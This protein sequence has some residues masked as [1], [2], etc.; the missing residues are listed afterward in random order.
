MR[1]EVFNIILGTVNTMRGT[2]VLHNTTM[3]SAPMVNQNFFEDMLAEEAN[4]HWATH[5][6]MLL[7]WTPWGGVASSTPHRYQEEVVL[8]SRP[9]ESNHPEEVGFHVA[10]CEFRKMWEPKISK[11]KGHYSSSAG[12]I[13]QS[14]LKDIC[15]HVE[16]RKLTQREAIQLVK[17]FTLECAQDEVAFY[18]GMIVEEDQSFEGL[19][20][21]LHDAFQSGEILSELI[22]DFY[23]Q[24]PKARETKDTFANDLQVLARKII[25][26]KPSFRKEAYQQLKAQYAH[27]LQHQYYAAMAHSA[28]QP[29]P[30]EESFTRFQGCLVTMFGGCTR[31]C[32]SSASSFTTS[33]IKSGVNVVK[34]TK[35]KLSKNSRQWQNKINQQEAQIK[36]LQTKTQQLWDLL[37]SK[38]LVS[39]ISQ[40][41]TTSLKLGSQL[42]TKGWCRC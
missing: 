29:S 4:L 25:A 2:A 41:V 27:K 39:V 30:E 34:E 36:S 21:H 9:T 8:P 19:I 23:G 12:L 22:S 15:V 14:W 33:S 7:L 37:D 40:A 26:H 35:G 3:A 10:T 32:Q 24:S 1:E 5:Q 17:D 38:S 42:M 16:D 20:D 28:L 31:Q 18:M 11:L 6:S 13:F